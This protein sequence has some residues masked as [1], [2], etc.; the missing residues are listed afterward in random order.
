LLEERIALEGF[1][2]VWVRKKLFKN[3]TV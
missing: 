3:D 2:R 1:V